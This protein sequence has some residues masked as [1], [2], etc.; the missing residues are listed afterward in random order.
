MLTDVDLTS[1]S[2]PNGKP[3]P[4]IANRNVE[5][6]SYYDDAESQEIQQPALE[7]G[8]LVRHDSFGLGTVREF[9]DMG[10]DSIAVVKFNTGQ[11]KSIMLKY[12]SLSKI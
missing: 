12:A 3:C 4:I 9:I 10:E 11:T 8:D 6:Q 1:G 5:N 7:K 2:K